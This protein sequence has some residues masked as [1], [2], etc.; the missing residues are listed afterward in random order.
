M[1]GSEGELADLG[2]VREFGPVNK[3]DCIPP[4]INSPEK[5]ETVQVHKPNLPPPKFKGSDFPHFKLLFSRYCD[6][7]GISDAYQRLG[8]LVSCLAPSV[9]KTVFTAMQHIFESERPTDTALLETLEQLYVVNVGVTLKDLESF[10]W[11]Q[12]QTSVANVTYTLDRLRYN[13]LMKTAPPQ[14]YGILA[15]QI[16]QP[17]V[18]WATLKEAIGKAPEFGWPQSAPVLAVEASQPGPSDPPVVNKSA[19]NRRLD[20]RRKHFEKQQARD[21]N[22]YDNVCRYHRKFG[23]EA[24]LCGLNGCNFPR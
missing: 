2:I 15:Q 16:Q 13:M 1:T 11:D 20:R 24:R 10:R 9:T 5:V 7:N 22:G 6:D 4:I 8:L 18:S 17:E 21:K 12:A 14:V 3:P 19:V 23:I